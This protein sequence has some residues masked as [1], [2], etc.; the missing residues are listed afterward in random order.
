[1]EIT[2]HVT[3]DTGQGRW[4]ATALE[5]DTQQPHA[6][7]RAFTL[8][9]RVNNQKLWEAAFAVPRGGSSPG[10]QLPLEDTV[11]LFA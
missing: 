9:N 11:G 8:R 7:T 2:K 10:F 3:L 4:T 6:S 1:M 5:E